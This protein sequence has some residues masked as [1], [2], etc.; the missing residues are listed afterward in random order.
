MHRELAQSPFVM[1][2]EER[3]VVAGAI[4]DHCEIRGWAIHAL[5]VRT[6]HVHI[7]VDCRETHTP[8]LA[9]AQFKS[10]GTRRLL[11]A[12]LIEHGRRIWTDHGSTRWIN[13]PGKLMLAKDY[14]LNCQ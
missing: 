8:E 3:R 1:A 9:M 7:V 13:D 11:T 14:V 6:N 5:N 4:R 2:D 12:G 10:W